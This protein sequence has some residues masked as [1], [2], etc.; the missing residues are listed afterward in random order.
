MMTGWL[1]DSG[2]EYYLAS[3]GKMVTG[4]QKINDNWYY[5]DHSGEMARNTWIGSHYVGDDGVRQ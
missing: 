5:F 2:T 4:W 3:S 1:N